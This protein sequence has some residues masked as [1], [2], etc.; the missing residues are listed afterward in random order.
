MSDMVILLLF[1]NSELQEKFIIPIWKNIMR[2]LRN[3]IYQIPAGRLKNAER[4]LQ[5]ISNTIREISKRNNFQA[6][7][8]QRFFKGRNKKY[9]EPTMF[10]KRRADNIRAKMH[11]KHMN[12]KK[13]A[14][15]LNKSESYIT[16]LI[17]GERYSKEFEIFIYYE[18]GF[19]YRNLK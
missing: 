3:F 19:S 18:L 16:R 5:N 1:Q 10:L 2:Y 14:K 13:M 17:N 9:K 4:M 8:V 15:L 6:K 12:Q 11:L 7:I